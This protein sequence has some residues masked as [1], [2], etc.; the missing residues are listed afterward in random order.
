MH[1]RHVLMVN[2]FAYNQQ[3]AA[4]TANIEKMFLGFHEDSKQR[5]CGMYRAHVNFMGKCLLILKHESRG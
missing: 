1:E 2:M 4:Q 3:D 5:G